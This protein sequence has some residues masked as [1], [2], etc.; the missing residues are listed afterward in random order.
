MYLFIMLIIPVVIFKNNFPL[1]FDK[2]QFAK[3]IIS[4]KYRIE[5]GRSRTLSTFINNEQIFFVFFTDT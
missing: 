1:W 5:T 4:A 3:I 2:M